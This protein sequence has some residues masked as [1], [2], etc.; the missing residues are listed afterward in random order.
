[1]LVFINYCGEI[2]AGLQYLR[3]SYTIARM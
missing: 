2:A 3:T 1:M